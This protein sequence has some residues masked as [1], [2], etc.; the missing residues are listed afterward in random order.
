MG[1]KG[2]IHYQRGTDELRMKNIR[3]HKLVQEFNNCT[4]EDL[5]R[6]ESIIKEFPGTLGGNPSI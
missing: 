4:I 6:K 3:V 5:K 1:D 2:K